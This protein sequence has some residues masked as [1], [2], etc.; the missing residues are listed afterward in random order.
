[1]GIRDSCILADSAECNVLDHVCIPH[2]HARAHS[3]FGQGL[4]S[5][6]DPERAPRALVSG[7]E[8]SQRSH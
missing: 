3:T 7:N 8:T 1:M 6:S 5:F 2:A 4:V